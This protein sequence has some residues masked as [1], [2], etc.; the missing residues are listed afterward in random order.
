L[1][2]LVAEC[3]NKKVVIEPIGQ[4]GIKHAC[5]SMHTQIAGTERQ[6]AA[7]VQFWR[8]VLPLHNISH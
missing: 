7:C 3:K 8:V 1:D 2:F 5:M 6:Q 4:G